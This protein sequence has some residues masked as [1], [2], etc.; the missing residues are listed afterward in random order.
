MVNIY[1]KYMSWR[2]KELKRE[3][4]YQTQEG[5]RLAFK[6]VADEYKKYKAGETCEAMQRFLSQKDDIEREE[7]L[8][9]TP[10]KQKKKK[11]AV[12][13]KEVEEIEEVEDE[14]KET[15]DIETV[16]EKPV[17]EQ[18][19]PKPPGRKIPWALIGIGVAVTVG[20]FYFLS[21]RKKSKP[22]EIAEPISEPA[23]EIF[24]QP[25]GEQSQSTGAASMSVDEARSKGLIP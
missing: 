5:H 6:I 19:P 1:N 24:A 7:V 23:P 17:R 18:S 15:N 11:E 10:P 3:P 8:K 20:I 13:V 25:V 14:P 2:L 9:P 22:P 21:K 12:K 4:Q 16:I